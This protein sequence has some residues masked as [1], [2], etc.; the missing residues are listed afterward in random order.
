MKKINTSTAPVVYC[1]GL[2]L[3]A[4]MAVLLAGGLTWLAGALALLV[5]LAGAGVGWLLAAQVKGLQ[6][7]V[8]EYLDGQTGFAGEII[9]VWKRHFESSREQMES[10]V[11]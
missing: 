9:P 6:Q 2:G 3:G 8:A 10:A 1:S 11:N 4:A 7:Q 5:A